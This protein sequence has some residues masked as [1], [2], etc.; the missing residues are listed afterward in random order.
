M[1]RKN[2]TQ[3]AGLSYI[4]TY[5]GCLINHLIFVFAVL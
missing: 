2:P 1:I 4:V 5:V 3:T